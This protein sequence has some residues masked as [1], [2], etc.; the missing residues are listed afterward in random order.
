[1]DVNSHQGNHTDELAVVFADEV[2]NHTPGEKTEDKNKNL[3]TALAHAITHEA[4]HTF[5]LD[6]T[7]AV[8]STDDQQLLT[9][10]DVVRK[11][12][13]TFDA[14]PIITRFPLQFQRNT[15]RI[16]NYDQLVFDPD[17]GPVD[18]NGDQVPD[19]AY[20]T[21][22]GAHDV[23]FLFDG[24]K[25]EKGRTQVQVNVQPFRDA[26]HTQ[27]IDI[28]GDGVI[29]VA[30]ELHCTITVGLKKT[31]GLDGT[32]GPIRIDAGLGSDEIRIDKDISLPVIVYGGDGDDS[33]RSGSGNDSLY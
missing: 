31:E 4:S 21:G 6:H 17:I 15:E 3:P 7:R 26:K 5:G 16:N 14:D 12:P 18:N 13:T 33:I 23:I 1:T 25:D 24:G 8:G 32:E 10:G 27:P 20:V 11:N 2:V 30:D 28:N 19:L 9:G 29:N 22:T